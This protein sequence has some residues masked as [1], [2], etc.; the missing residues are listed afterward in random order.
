M[1]FSKRT[2]PAKPSLSKVL[3][4]YA[5]KTNCPECRQADSAVSIWTVSMLHATIESSERALSHCDSSPNHVS[6]LTLL[7]YHV[8]QSGSEPV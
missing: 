6:G 5:T 4:S 2:F 8:F 7:R 1:H 3:L